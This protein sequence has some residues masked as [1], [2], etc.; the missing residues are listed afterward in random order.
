ML[1]LLLLR[2]F[3]AF[4]C[5]VYN[6]QIKDLLNTSSKPLTINEDRQTGVVVVAG[7]TEAVGCQG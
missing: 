2:V 7:L 4:T 6:E 5:Q 1:P 3:L